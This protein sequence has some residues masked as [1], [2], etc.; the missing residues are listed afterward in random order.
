VTRALREGRLDEVTELWCDGALV[1]WQALHPAGERRTVRLPVYP[2]ARRRYWVPVEGATPPSDSPSATASAPA[3]RLAPPDR[4]AAS[5]RPGLP[6]RPAPG[7]ELDT[8]AYAAVLDAVLDGSADPDDL[9][10]V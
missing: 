8:G 3:D 6:E 7:G 4:Q 9:G 5:A 1:D 10:R 2:F